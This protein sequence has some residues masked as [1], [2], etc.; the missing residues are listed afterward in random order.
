METP[1]TQSKAWQ[2]LQND[3]NEPNFYNAEKEYV[4]L[5]I[6]KSTPVG[7][8]LYLPYG[9]VATTGQG[10][11]HALDSL[12]VL[13]KQQNAVFIRIEPQNPNLIEALKEQGI[14]LE[15]SLD[16]NP[17]ETWLLDLTGTEDDLKEKLPSRLLRY[18]KSA[19][20]KGITIRKSHDPADI[21]FLLDLQKALA[22][23]KNIS[24]FSE[25]YLK[26]ELKQPFATLYLVEYRPPEPPEPPET[27][28]PLEPPT[29]I[30]AGLVFDDDKTRYNL[31][32]AQSDEGRKLHA[33]GILTIELIKDA[34]AQNL[35]TFDF[36]GI[37][38]DGAPQDHPWQG[39]TEFKKTFAGSEAKYAGTYD[40]I[41]KPVKYQL[42]KLLRK[43]RRM[44]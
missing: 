13:A 43:F 41:L 38:P 10:I 44:V 36:W 6:A 35:Q 37:A 31:Q 18:H 14:K 29:I 22:K 11:K 5:A 3:L 15:K 28:E 20:K 32:G 40:L 24:T 27:P 25:E 4:Y 8:Y 23:T 42:Y 1:I 33:T 17:A 19:E 21:H 2:A 12:M 30:A 39:F 34:K 7:K 26:T 9:P 16:L